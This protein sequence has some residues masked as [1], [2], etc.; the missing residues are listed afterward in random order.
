MKNIIIIGLLLF[1]VSLSADELVDDVIE[2]NIAS[3]MASKYQSLRQRFSN[4]EDALRGSTDP[5]EI[6]IATKIFNDADTRYTP[7]EIKAEF[8][9]YCVKALIQRRTNELTL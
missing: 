5:D 4:V 3:S 7:K 2:C 6:A 8:F 9:D 1:T